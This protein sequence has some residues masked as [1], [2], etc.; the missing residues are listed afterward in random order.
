M[1]FTAP[2]EKMKSYDSPALESVPGV[3]STE[4]QPSTYLP[5]WVPFELHARFAIPTALP[6]ALLCDLHE[7]RTVGEGW[8]RKLELADVSFYIDSR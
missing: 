1:P 6:C 3:S 2:W 4:D 5:L 7:N 8:K